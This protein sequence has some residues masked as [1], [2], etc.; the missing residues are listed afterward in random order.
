MEITKLLTKCG[1]FKAGLLTYY[2]HLRY[3]GLVFIQIMKR[4]VAFLYTNL[5]E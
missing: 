3:C 4:V 1:E 2:I 5:E